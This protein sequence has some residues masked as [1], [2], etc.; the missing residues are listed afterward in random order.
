MGGR[1]VKDLV[2]LIGAALR[3]ARAQRRR[4]NLCGGN[5]DLPQRV[6]AGDPA[7][8][9]LQWRGAVT[10]D[11]FEGAPMPAVIDLPV[12]LDACRLEFMDSSGLGRLCTLVRACHDAKQPLVVVNPADI[13]KGYVETMGM[14]LLFPMVADEDEAMAWLAERQASGGTS[15][16][17]ENG[18]VWVS[19]NRSLDAAYHEEMMGVLEEAISGAADGRALVVDLKDVGFIDSRAVGGLIRA[20][21]MITAKGGEMFL[22]RANPAVREIIAL[23]RLDHI[24]AEWKGPVTE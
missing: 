7:V 6:A 4:K 16:V 18:A 20:L 17:A 11:K 5:C 21:K 14:K 13:F 8:I 9:R 22:A 10:Y 1:Y 24:L 23:L 2:F 12:L 15:R 3:Q 19:F